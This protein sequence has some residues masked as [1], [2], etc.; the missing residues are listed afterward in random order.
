MGQVQRVALG[1]RIV[2]AVDRNRWGAGLLIPTLKLVKVYAGGVLHRA[3]KFLGAYG[4]AI[5]SRKV[6]VHA[7]AKVLRT[8]QGMDHAYDFCAF[9]ID[10]RGVEVTDLHIRFGAYRM[11]HGSRV[12]RKLRAT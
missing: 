12:F 2:F 5:V 4:L 7:G 11:R 8:D 6:Q 3:D 1:R 10:R 9:A